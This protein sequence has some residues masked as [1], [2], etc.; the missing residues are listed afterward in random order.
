VA[1]PVY[2]HEFIADLGASS[3]FVTP[4]EVGYVILI[5][6]LDWFLPSA[7]A[8]GSIQMIGQ[9]GQVI[10]SADYGVLL[11]QTG[12]W[13][14]KYVLNAGETL[15]VLSTESDSFHCSVA[16]DLLTATP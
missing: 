12:M 15:E 5:T 11:G 9:P 2:S 16:G 1:S 13:R 14:G 7:L 8:I 6:T 10:Y 3:Y 4:P